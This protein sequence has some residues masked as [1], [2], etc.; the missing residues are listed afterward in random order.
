MTLALLFPGQGV[1]HPGMLHWLQDEPMAQ[2]ALTALAACLGAEWRQRLDDEAW[3]SSN[4]VAQPLMTGVALAAWQALAPQLPRPGVLAGYSVG[5][6]PAFCA[7]GLFDVDTALRLA[8]QRAALMDACAG[9]EPAGLL[10]V[11]GV[12]GAAIERLCAEG[13]LAV[14]IRLAPDRCVLGGTLAALAAARPWLLGQGAELKL[15]RVQVASHTPAM[16]AA[17]A[18]FQAL[19]DPMDWR[20]P[21]GVLVCNLDGAGRRDPSA[22]KRA[23]AQQIDHALAWDRCLVSIAERQPRCVLEIGPGST[24]AR[25]WAAAC[26][27]VP[28]RSID[29][30][31]RSDAVVAWVQQVLAG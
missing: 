8:R 20:R 13:V 19:L 6:L 3:S 21:E 29:E 24:L 4:A 10:S 15:L 11:S 16:A 2:P 17:A 12:G 5:E 22:L 28:V 25:Q 23:L 9:G 30:F 14:A 31:H 26:P 1:Q 7:A 18:G 27:D